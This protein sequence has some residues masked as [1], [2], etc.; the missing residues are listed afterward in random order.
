M[1]ISKGKLV[2]WIL[3]VVILTVSF[4]SFDGDY[5]KAFLFVAFLMPAALGTSFLINTILIPRYLLRQR[6]FKFGLYV[7]YTLVIS[8]YLEMVAVLLGFTLLANFQYQNLGPYTQNIFFLTITLY[9]IVLLEAFGKLLFSF[10]KR[11][12][13]LQDM[14]EKEARNSVSSLVVKS[15]RET[16]S[17]PINEIFYIESL[18][19]YVKIYSQRGEV[20][21]KERISRLP[22]R[23]SDDFVRIHRSFLVNRNFVESFTSQYVIVNKKELPIGRKFKEDALDQLAPGS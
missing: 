1:S 17:I 8:L 14:E 2:F 5:S 13:E 9:F 6:Y 23:L 16:V 12:Q 15:N 21:T 19:D 18:S 20:L 22:D 7:F 11:S 10:Q 4:G 3:I